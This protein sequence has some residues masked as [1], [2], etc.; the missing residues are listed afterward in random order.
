MTGKIRFFLL[1]VVMVSIAVG[2]GATAILLLYQV[3]LGRQRERL[4]E[5]AKSQARMIEAIARYNARHLPEHAEMS[6]REVFF[7][8]T[9]SQIR[10]AHENFDTFGETGEFFLGIHEADQIVFLLSHSGDEL[11]YRQP[12]PYDSQW[13]EPMRRALADEEG[14]MVVSDYRG[15]KVLAAYEPVRGINLAI[16]A[17]IDMAE[18]RAP[19]VR[20]G[21]LAGASGLAITALGML[22]FLRISNPIARQLEE[23]ERKYRG[24]FESSGDILLLYDSQGIIQDA[25]PASCSAL[26]YA[27]DELLGRHIEG[28]VSESRIYIDI[29]QRDSE[30]LSGSEEI[31]F[32][33]VYLKR[34][35]LPFPVD[36]RL[37]PLRHRDKTVAL[38]SARDMTERKLAE[39]RIRM[40]SA[41]IIKAQEKERKLVAQDIHDSLGTCLTAIKYSLE[42][43]MDDHVKGLGLQAEGL[44][45]TIS[46]VQ[47]A[48]EES[49]RISTNLRPSVLDDL[50]ILP[51]ISWF[52]RQFEAIYS[53]IN[54]IKETD[55]EESEVPELLKIVIFRILQ[56]ALMNA[57][58]H[59]SADTVRVS[60][61]RI[62]GNIEL[63][64]SDNGKGFNPEEQIGRMMPDSKI[65]LVG[66]KE[67]V[68]LA[69]G[70]I[71]VRSSAGKGTSI[72]AVWPCK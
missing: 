19:F 28:L 46:M 54:L 8:T 51:T 52:C 24:I 17:K 63:C 36:V 11:E 66:M 21:F 70:V 2:V 67:R 16:V 31:K 59:S 3:S 72:R 43:N 53:D 68:E 32:E 23:N 47:S 5:T 27:Q 35:G 26:G 50:G 61:A 58:K 15:Q 64:V 65:G 55:I 39:E 60:L 41:E 13:A 42:K 25:N 69:G 7:R 14:T 9:L 71:Q 18:I 10:S 49:R 30:A 45:K 48:I 44:A 56:E 62:G 22:L 6:D 29:F 12:I 57:A 34:N 20:A 37:S 40:L 4:V 1:T 38:A 33:S